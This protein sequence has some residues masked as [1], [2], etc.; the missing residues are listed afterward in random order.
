MARWGPTVSPYV[1]R[2]PGIAEALQEAAEIG[3]REYEAQRT[4]KNQLAAA[5]AT[6]VPGQ[7]SLL[8]KILGRN[9]PEDVPPPESTPP[10]T[11]TGAA[12]PTMTG[13]LPTGV[14]E[15]IAESRGITDPL[16]TRGPQSSSISEMIDE[17][18]KP[19]EYRSRGGKRY[20]VPNPE[21][22]R[23]R[24][25]EVSRARTVADAIAAENRKMDQFREQERIRHENDMELEESRQG[26]RTE[27]AGIKAETAAQ[28]QAR[29]EQAAT[30]LAQ[31][32]GRITAANRANNTSE[33][34]RL[35]DIQ[36]NTLNAQLGAL[37]MPTGVDALMMQSSP[38]G[39]QQLQSIQDERTALISQLAELEAD[40]AAMRSRT[41]GGTAPAPGAST[42]GGAAGGTDPMD[43]PNPNM[44]GKTARQRSQQLQQAGVAPD[45][46]LATLRRE[47]Y[48]K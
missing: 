43:I 12:G 18:F 38:E 34:L 22:G 11:Q 44:G 2:R 3:L 24:I 6:E 41:G 14:A 17:T 42:G 32:R 28:A 40:A 21:A 29:R 23:A 13:L 33:A 47:G 35:M 8:D 37:K 26:G 48:I 1:D 4:E 27:L 31:L 19:S 16:K 36:R 5:G 20:S 46:I 9:K 30:E 25:E 15:R 39:Q 45:R 7:R 10:A